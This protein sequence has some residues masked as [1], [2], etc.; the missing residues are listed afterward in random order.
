MTQRPA[1]KRH[2]CRSRRHLKCA[3]LACR[4]VHGWKGPGCGTQCGLEGRAVGLRSVRTLGLNGSHCTGDPG[5]PV[6]RHVDRRN[7]VAPTCS[8]LLPTGEQAPLLETPRKLTLPRAILT[9]APRSR[10]RAPDDQVAT[11]ERTLAALPASPEQ[12]QRGEGRGAGARCGPGGSV[13]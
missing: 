7:E 9:S 5:R 8:F 6:H 3:D 12:E 2:R 4:S 1:T 10:S 13:P 11:W